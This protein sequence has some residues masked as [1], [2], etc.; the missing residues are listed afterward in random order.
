MLSMMNTK[1]TTSVLA[2]VLLLVGCA[3]AN[4]VVIYVTPTPGEAATEAIT[5]NVAQASTVVLPT[6][7][8]I[9]P[10]DDTPTLTPGPTVT[11]IGSIIGDD[12]VPPATNTPAPT[13]PPSPATTAVPQ[14][15]P[16]DTP[17]PILEATDIPLPTG[18]LIP[19]LDTSNVGIQIESFL[20]NDDKAEA[21]NQV[22]DDLQLGWVKLQIAWNLYQPSSPSEVNQELR[23]IET[24]IEQIRLQ[25]QVNVLVSIAKAPDW[26]RSDLTEDGPPNDPQALANFISLLLTETNG[27]IAAVE[28]W[29]EPNLAR[30]WRGQPITGAA[31]MRYFDAGYRAVKAYDPNIMVVSAGLAPTGDS[32]FTRDDRAFLREMYAAG[33][34]NYDGIAVGVHPYGWGN[35]PDARCC[36]LSDERGWDDAPQFFYLDTL[37]DYREIMV[38]AGHSD[39]QMWLTEFG[40]ATWEG[41]PGEPP[42]I[43]MT[44]NSKWD[45]ANYT[46]RAIQIAQSRADIGPLFLWNLNFAQPI[47]I[48][49]RDERVA[50]SIVLPEGVPRERPLYWMLFDAARPDEQL[51]RYD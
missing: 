44:Y 19:N 43:W 20:T 17:A 2:L 40:W 13:T 21:L 14:T 30:E 7:Q 6:D 45:Q 24:F 46:L 12:Y 1:I 16:T 18:T 3:Q 33:L 31:Y 35:P 42:Q 8:I 51:P 29:N 23:R 48:D 22:E 41:L 49:Q 9:Q 4:P 10:T 28:I 32:E 50:Y 38:A 37:D 36:D 11:F 26:A 27:A 34:A 47:L 15:E 5:A 39:T 25:R